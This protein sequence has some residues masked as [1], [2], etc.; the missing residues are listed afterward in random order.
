M[1]WEDVSDARTSTPNL[2]VRDK[3]SVG[4]K[5]SFERSLVSCLN[6]LFFLSGID[7]KALTSI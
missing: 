3:T 2:H 4:S 5:F 7:G 6:F 1:L